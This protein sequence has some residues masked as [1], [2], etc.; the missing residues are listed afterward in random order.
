MEQEIPSY[1]SHSSFNLAI[2]GLL[3]KAESLG[4]LH[5]LVFLFGFLKNFN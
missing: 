1:D 2:V 5:Y 3:I 4:L